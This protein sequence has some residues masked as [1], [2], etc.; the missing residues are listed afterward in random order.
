MAGL[1]Q[2]LPL[3]AAAAPPDTAAPVVTRATATMV[4]QAVE[5]IARLRQVTFQN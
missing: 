5:R 2:V 4:K 1:L 3:L